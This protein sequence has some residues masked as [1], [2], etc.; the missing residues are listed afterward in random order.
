MEINQVKI[1]TPTY[2]TPIVQ[3]LKACFLLSRYNKKYPELKSDVFQMSPETELRLK[4]N[5][6]YSRSQKFSIDDYNSLSKLEKAILREVYTANKQAALDSLRV[7]I[8]VKQK[9]DKYEGKDKYAFCCIGTS[10]S[11]IARVLE[12]MGVETKYLPISQ[13]NWL[14]CVED[15]KLHSHKFANYEKFMDE[16]GLSSEKVSKSDKKYLFYDFVQQGMSIIV[17]EKMMKEHFGLDL[18]N[19]EFNNVNYL[20][21]SACAENIEPPQYAIDYI[22]T[23]MNSN[24]ICDFGGVPHLPIDQID[25]IE[26]CKEYET[27]TAKTF[28]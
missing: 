9:L 5:A 13:L 26:K 11:G 1:A 20:C 18:P 4:A 27:L 10:P 21:Q 8:K 15:W 24:G 25:E 7:G 12:F 19:V 28:N 6:I 17:F 14:D 3:R 23:Y 2:K 22:E 16:Q